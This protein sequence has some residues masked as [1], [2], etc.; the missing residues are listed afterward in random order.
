[1]GMTVVQFVPPLTRHLLMLMITKRCR[2]ATIL[3]FFSVGQGRQAAVGEL[4]S[5]HRV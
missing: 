4:K 2:P 5:W 1:M 3:A